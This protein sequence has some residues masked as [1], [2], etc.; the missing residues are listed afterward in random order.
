MAIVALDGQFCVPIGLGYHIAGTPS[1]SVTTIDA[2]NEAVIMI[3]YIATSDQ[4]SHTIDTTGS[5]SIGWRTQ[6]VTFANA[7]TTAVVGLADVDATAG[8]PARAVNSTDVI[9]F[10]VSRSM[11]GG[12]GGVTSNQ[13]QEHVP[14]AGTKT[15]AHGDFIAMAIQLTARAG[16]DSIAVTTETTA[17][18]QHRPQVT[19]FLG[20]SYAATTTV[21]NMIITFSDGA[22]GYF[23]A[24][25]TYTSINTRTWNSGDAIKEYGQLFAL[26]F[27]VSIYGL[28]GHLDADANCDMVL[29]SDPLGTPVA[30]RTVSIDL[31][32]VASTNARRLALLFPTPYSATAGQEIGAVFK[33]GASNVS[34]SYKT[35]FSAA[36]RVVFPSGVNGFGISRDTGAFADANSGQDNYYIGLIVGGFSDGAGGGVTPL[37]NGLHPIGTG[38][39]A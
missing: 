29:Y 26:P 36:H 35:Q 37:G 27:P 22:L 32:T 5:S 14:T 21:P 9:T 28:Y 30:E 33:P 31:N 8:P 19:S 2:T 24:T 4:G 10:D 6:S 34:T 12:G 15:V 38:V 25:E 17:V 39:G 7:G 13:W 1:S 16:A 20:G 23:H 11:T 18:T 3:G